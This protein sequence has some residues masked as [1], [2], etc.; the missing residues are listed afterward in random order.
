MASAVE[1][2][3]RT[4]SFADV[5]V[6]PPAAGLSAGQYVYMGV[7]ADRP[8]R[9]R[10]W[11]AWAIIAGLA[12]IVGFSSPLAFLL[13]VPAG[14]YAVHLFGG[15][16]DVIRQGHDGTRRSAIWL[17]WAAIAAVAFIV[18][19]AHPAGFL[20]ALAAGAYTTYLYR[21]GRWVF[22]IW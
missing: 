16:R 5:A 3:A 4:G 6:A 19:F 13:A 8:A 1:A 22:W 11:V 12:A 2:A 20:I 15:G 21:G 17:Y 9:T 10:A 7:A 18:G 14:A